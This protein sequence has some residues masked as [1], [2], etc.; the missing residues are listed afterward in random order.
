MNAPLRLFFSTSVIRTAP[1][2]VACA[3]VG[4]MLTACA[5]GSPFATGAVD[6]SSPVAAEVA[7]LAKPTGPFPKFTDIPPVPTDERPVRAWGQAADQ[8]EAAAARLERETADNTWT[9]TPG[10][11]EA[12]A[13]GAQR[14]AGPALASD[15]S[16]TAASEAFARQIRERATP[17]PLPR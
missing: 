17:P 11:T 7:R 8:L 5:G 12:F 16:T 4:A 3:A 2:L 10:A 1:R 13:A 9:L 14:Q 15:D 6:P